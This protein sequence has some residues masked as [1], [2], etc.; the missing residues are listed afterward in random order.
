MGRGT[1]L[2]WLSALRKSSASL[3]ELKNWIPMHSKK[4]KEKS[5]VGVELRAG[6]DPHRSQKPGWSAGGMKHKK[7]MHTHPV[8]P[9][10]VLVLVFLTCSRSSKWLIL[11]MTCSKLEKWLILMTCPKSAKI[12]R[13]S[14]PRSSICTLLLLH[15]C[16]NI[17]EW[18]IIFNH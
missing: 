17:I 1:C 4:K 14:H 3:G 15:L 5:S 11:L 13:S 7:K 10:G 8:S 18:P 6:G 16:L 12:L 9:T 2:E